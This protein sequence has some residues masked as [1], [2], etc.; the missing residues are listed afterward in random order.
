MNANLK[1]EQLKAEQEQ[2]TRAD[3]EANRL[4]RAFRLA[5]DMFPEL[6]DRRTLE[7]AGALVY[8]FDQYKKQ[9]YH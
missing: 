6:D 9:H 5:R 2:Q 8:A 1:N 7:M 3:H 4:K